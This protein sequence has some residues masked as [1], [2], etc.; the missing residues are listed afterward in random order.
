M[1]SNLP[2]PSKIPDMSLD[3]RHDEP[4]QSVN[5]D[6]SS[7]FQAQAAN[8]ADWLLPK[9]DNLGDHEVDRCHP[10]ASLPVVGIFAL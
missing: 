8:D 9:L 4:A 10:L 6:P 2:D 3:D 5:P 1:P 7:S